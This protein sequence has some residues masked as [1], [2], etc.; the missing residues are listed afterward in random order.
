MLSTHVHSARPVDLPGVAAV[1]QEAFSD[2]MRRIFTNQPEKIR[3]LLEA[4]YSGPV[5][6]GYDGVLVA[7]R[8]GRIIG[9]LLIEPMFYT[10][11]ENRAFEHLAVRELGLLRMLWGSFL[12]WL[13]T[14]RPQPGEAYISDLGVAPDC[15]G[16]GV[17]R[18][19][20]EHA[21]E[22]ARGR[23][24]ERLTLW[25]AG[26]NERALHLYENFGFQRTRT[27]NSMLTRL[28]FGIRRWYFMEKPLR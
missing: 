11:Q 15:Q 3:T 28:T 19:L 13:V 1:L 26:S 16:E 10:S 21:E 5:H 7:E 27:R 20:L 8:G 4:A 2:K 9:T 22:W 12:L 18:L 6:R 24:R 23:E 17:G 14:H 25:V